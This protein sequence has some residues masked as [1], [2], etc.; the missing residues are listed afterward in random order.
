MSDSEASDN[1]DDSRTSGSGRHQT[2]PPPEEHEHNL[3]DG[4]SE[5]LPD[6]KHNVFDS[7][8]DTI[9]NTD[10]RKKTHTKV[11]EFRHQSS[12]DSEDPPPAPVESGTVVDD[13]DEPADASRCRTSSDSGRG[14]PEAD[15]KPESWNDEEQ[16]QDTNPNQTIAPEPS[17]TQTEVSVD[18]VDN[19]EHNNVEHKP[20]TRKKKKKR[21]KRREK[22]KREPPPVYIPQFN[23]GVEGLPNLPDV[24][25]DKSHAPKLNIDHPNLSKKPP[26]RLKPIANKPETVEMGPIY[27]SNTVLPEVQPPAN[28]RRKRTESE[29]SSKSDPRGI[30]CDIN[31]S[32]NVEMRPNRSARERRRR[33]T[34]SEGRNSD[35]NTDGDHPRSHSGSLD[36][37]S[38]DSERPR[39][40][41]SKSNKSEAQQNAQSV[42]R[43]KASS[44]ASHQRRLTNDSQTALLG[45]SG[46]SVELGELK[47]Q[48]QTSLSECAMGVGEGVAWTRTGPRHAKVRDVLHRTLSLWE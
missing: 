22:S 35:Q 25:R 36:R 23:D 13:T 3:S 27:H 28:G 45:G 46:S 37:R 14:S 7:G 1:G 43:R 18:N 47:R 33:R 12:N 42:P 39:R 41:K 4:R 29:S 2:D 30:D 8:V 17:E 48:S 40:S 21:E 10:E 16:D 20:R 24:F 26:P 15:K 38:L 5:E 34:A 44:R 31:N 19:I 32:N 6:I 9:Y 11:E